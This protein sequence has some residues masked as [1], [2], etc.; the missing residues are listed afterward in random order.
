[1]SG[2]PCHD[3]DM[4]QLMFRDRNY[5]TVVDEMIGGERS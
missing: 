4:R 5:K 3:C 2:V 1:M